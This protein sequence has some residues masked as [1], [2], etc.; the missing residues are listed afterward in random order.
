MVPLPTPTSIYE[1]VIWLH[2]PV[3]GRDWH[4]ESPDKYTAPF[5]SRSDLPDSVISGLWASTLHF[6]IPS[7]KLRSYRHFCYLIH[8]YDI[9]A[10]GKWEHFILASILPSSLSGMLVHG[11]MFYITSVSLPRA[12]ILVSSQGWSQGCQ[13]NKGGTNPQS[14]LP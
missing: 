4:S 11:I 14:L 13:G 5:S 9:W 2:T 7:A 1:S 8:G 12:D 3:Q 10:C 6:T